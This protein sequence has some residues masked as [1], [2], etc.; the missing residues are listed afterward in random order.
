MFFS[1]WWF[2]FSLVSSTIDITERSNIPESTVRVEFD[3]YLEPDTV[4]YTIVYTCKVN[5]E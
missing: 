1:V 3:V 2:L 5:Y 4:M